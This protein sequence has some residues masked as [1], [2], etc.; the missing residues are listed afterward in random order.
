MLGLTALGGLLGLDGTSVGQFM[1]SRPLV[2]GV[3]AGALVG[4]PLLGGLIG[5]VFEVYLLV[6]FPTGGSR[7][8]EGA[9]ATVVAVGSSAGLGAEGGGALALAIAVGLAWG[10]VGGLSISWLRQV[11]G[12]IVSRQG[13]HGGRSPSRVTALQVGAIALDFARAALVVGTGLVVG[14]A[15]L[16]AFAPAWPLDMRGSVGLVLV[17]ASVS[18]GILLRDFGGFRKNRIGFV[19]G[20]ALGLV[21]A[22][23]L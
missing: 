22:R 9:T 21:G 2:A 16:T 3:L 15:A 6:S 12:H 20:I 5:A 8:P 11:N 14:R 18:L 23:F 19:I 1:I 17:G 7:F 13:R 4:D 10:H